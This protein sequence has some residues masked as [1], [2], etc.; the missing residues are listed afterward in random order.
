LY[1]YDVTMWRVRV[2]IVAMETQKYSPFFIIIGVDV[3]VKNTR[4]LGFAAKTQ[5]LVPIALFPN[6]KIFPTSVEVLKVMTV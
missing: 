1:T 2:A 3:A 5:K 6:H 4:V